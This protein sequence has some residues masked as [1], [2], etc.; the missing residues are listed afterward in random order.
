[1]EKTIPVHIVM[2]MI[3]GLVHQSEQ[4][5]NLE[6]RIRLQDYLLMSLANIVEEITNNNN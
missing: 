3:E 2:Q 1:M 6:D 5:E 4:M